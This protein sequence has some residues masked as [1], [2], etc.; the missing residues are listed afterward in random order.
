MSPP[1]GVFKCNRCGAST[2]L[3]SGG[4]LGGWLLQD[5]M[6]FCPKCR[7]IVLR[8]PQEVIH[9]YKFH[10]STGRNAHNAEDM[11][12]PE[13]K[14]FHG[15][16]DQAMAH[17]GEYYWQRMQGEF[18]RVEILNVRFAYE[19]VGKIVVTHDVPIPEIVP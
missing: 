7:P 16:L 19:L 1:L 3:A 13:K 6:C 9:L 5:E 12:E 11:S 10:P 8:Q 4:S 14:E 2:G 18:T 15:L 17:G